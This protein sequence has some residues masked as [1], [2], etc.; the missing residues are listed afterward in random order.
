MQLAAKRIASRFSSSASS[1]IAPT[2]ARVDVADAKAT[3]DLLAAETPFLLLGARDDRR[4]CF[5]AKSFRLPHG[6]V[7]STGD[8]FVSV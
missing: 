1:A 3:S 6:S 8:H 4:T 5:T 7:P 2:I